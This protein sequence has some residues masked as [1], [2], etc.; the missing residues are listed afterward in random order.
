MLLNIV[1]KRDY[2]IKKQIMRR[3]MINDDSSIYIFIGLDDFSDQGSSEAAGY[4]E[5]NNYIHQSDSVS[6]V[7]SELNIE[8]DGGMHISTNTIT[9]YR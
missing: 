9:M 4:Y 2:Y 7:S 1:N 3:A 6:M 8:E 5:K